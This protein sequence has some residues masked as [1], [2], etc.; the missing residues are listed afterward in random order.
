[1]PG[2]GPKKAGIT[3]EDDKITWF[4]PDFLVVECTDAVC[5][6]C[7]GLMITPT[8][9]CGD[10]H[11]FCRNC[12]TKELRIRE[13]CPLCRVH[14][15]SCDLVYHRPMEA[16]IAR[17][18]VMC[19]YG[20]TRDQRREWLGEKTNDAKRLKP[21]VAESYSMEEL[22]SELKTRGVSHCGTK[23][24]MVNRLNEDRMR[25]FR[26]TR[27]ACGWKGP[28]GSVVEHSKVC[29]W[30]MITCA[31][32]GCSTETLRKEMGDHV[33]TCDLRI[34]CPNDGCDVLNLEGSMN[35][36]RLVCKFE[37]TECPSPGC[38]Q[39]MTRNKLNA[40]IIDKHTNNSNN[41]PLQLLINMWAENK[42]LRE[43][44]DSEQK[45]LA[46]STYNKTSPDENARTWVFNWK[47]DSW[48]PGV[49]STAKHDFGGGIFGKCSMFEG[50]S[51]ERP[52]FIG[53]M[54]TGISSCKI[55]A[56]FSLVSRDD[57]DDDHVYS[58]G[59]K[60]KPVLK[61]FDMVDF[62][63]SFFKPGDG[64]KDRSTREDGSVRLRAIIRIV[65]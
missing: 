10:G 29:N 56:R 51:E 23:D 30:V 61:N 38:L 16:M 49:Y 63:G 60:N 47:A 8:S 26:S 55:Y 31:N 54:I 44:D 21:E 9:G 28:L 13:K 62:W 11:S 12:L 35:V 41:T 52:Y 22:K 57:T 2:D 7:L 53:V 1:M 14:I 43:A 64:M 32:K 65:S 5:A 39:R 6:L 58:I 19:P 42:I 50:K 20:Q 40:H 27:L 46:A 17:Q 15:D 45:L 4:D 3:I 48:S 34:C 33:K 37:T 36:H 25:D 59:T 24:A 18:E